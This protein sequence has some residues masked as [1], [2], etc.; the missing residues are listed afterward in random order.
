MKARFIGY[1][2]LMLVTM[3]FPAAHQVS[4]QDNAG[5][6]NRVAVL[7]GAE[8]TSKAS[9]FAKLFYKSSKTPYQRFEVVAVGLKP[10]TDYQLF[11]N[12]VA[13][14]IKKSNTSGSIEFLF[15][16]QSKDAIT[17]GSLKLPTELSSV[18][19]IQNISIREKDLSVALIGEFS[20][21]LAP[22]ADDNEPQVL[23]L[24]NSVSMVANETATIVLPVSDPDGDAITVTVTCDRG[25]FITVSGLSLIMAPKDKD[26]GTHVCSAKVTDTFGLFTTI[27]FVITVT[28]ANRAPSISPIPDQIIKT[29]EVKD[30]ALQASDPDGNAG[31]RF[32]VSQGPAFVIVVDRGDGTAV[33]RIAPQA[34]DTQGGIVTVRVIDAG[35]LTAQ[36]SFTLTVNKAVTVSS[37]T[38]AKPNLFI[39]GVGFGQSGATVTINNQDL[40]S[41]IIG[42]S[43][44]SIT[45]KGSKKRLNLKP[46]ANQII[47]TSGGI[48]SNTF[49]LNMLDDEE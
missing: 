36:T 21:K 8:P 12:G 32:V 6:V 44:S 26:V 34:S 39:S 23:S 31:L 48:T 35:G 49:I 15:N 17:E 38:R 22:Q 29:G 28:A 19:S 37:V 30:I 18:L 40:S 24:L 41:R 33:L 43:D 1:I 14:D 9:G 16:S 2:V 5:S 45:L 10:A 11:V 7:K 13:F 3:L 4:A 42:Q 46:G 25:N 47:V 20:E 27:P